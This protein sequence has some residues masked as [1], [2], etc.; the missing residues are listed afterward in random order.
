MEAKSSVIGLA[1]VALIL[2]VVV[3]PEIID[4]LGTKTD[5]IPADSQWNSGNDLLK[6]L[7]LALGAIII[8]II[9]IVVGK[10]LSS[11]RDLGGGGV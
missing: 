8:I 3:A 6:T 10:W 1:V 5:D 7:W 11:R 4:T 2:L 9:I